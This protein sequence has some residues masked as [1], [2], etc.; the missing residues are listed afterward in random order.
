M[1]RGINVI[2]LVHEVERYIFLYDDDSTPE[3]LQTIGRFAGNPDLTFSWYDAAVLSQKV[4]RLKRE[5][6]EE[7]KLQKRKTDS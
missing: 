4:R 3:L 6:E 1:K 5:A 7:E 2:A